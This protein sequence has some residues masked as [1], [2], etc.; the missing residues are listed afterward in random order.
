MWETIKKDP[1]LKTVVIIILSVLGFGFAFNIMFGTNNRGVG[2]GEMSSSGEMMGGGSEMGGGYSLGNTL[3]NIFILAFNILLIVLVI[4]LIIMIIKFVKKNV[5]K[6]GEIKVI[7]TIKK[8]PFL[9]GL[10]IVGIVILSVWLISYLFNGMYG[11]G[12][13]NYMMNGYYVTGNAGYGFN[14]SLLLALLLKCLLFA[15]VVGLIVGLV[16]YIKQ[17]YGKQIAEKLSSINIVS[18]STA[19]CSHCGATTSEEFEFCPHCGENVKEVCADCNA[20]LKKEWKCC[21]V[22]GNEKAVEEQT[23]T[24]DTTKPT[25]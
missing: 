7:E 14:F 24:E 5:M 18:K 12:G 15:S 13:G 23:K 19:S 3:S 4:A 11:N 9:K 10:S 25:K 20:E 1:I 8:D 17:C 21:P 22:C 6:G 16:M 2:G